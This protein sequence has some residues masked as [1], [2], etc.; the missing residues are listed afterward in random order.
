[1]V[2]AFR[3]D[4][5]RAGAA[6]EVTQLVDE[7]CRASP[8]FKALWRDNDVAGARRGRQAPRPSQARPARAGILRLRRRRAARL[9]MIVYNPATA[10]TATKI[11]S[12]MAARQADG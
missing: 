1:M 10:E 11:R 4:A 7:L 9:G 3:A 8:E 12:L 6:S 5:A 2:G